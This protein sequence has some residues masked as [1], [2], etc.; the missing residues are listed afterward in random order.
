MATSLEHRRQAIAAA[1]RAAM[2]EPPNAV[3]PVVETVNFDAGRTAEPGQR[4]SLRE[5][6]TAAIDW[7]EPEQSEALGELDRS[8]DDL[9]SLDGLSRHEDI[10]DD[11]VTPSVPPLEVSG[12][13][14]S[15]ASLALF[16]HA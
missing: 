9:S 2:T 4:Q 7:D 14:S 13:M 12:S 16:G 1:L 5:A 15:V 8:P 11:W 6:L 3:E 10:D